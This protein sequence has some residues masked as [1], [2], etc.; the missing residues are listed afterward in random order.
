MCMSS[1][2]LSFTF[3]DLAFRFLQPGMDGTSHRRKHHRAYKVV[4]WYRYLVLLFLEEYGKMKV[5][6]FFMR[7]E[8]E[9]FELF[10]R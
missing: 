9:H 1:M 7:M 2:M 4:V 6:F 8:P 10:L 3:R 5:P